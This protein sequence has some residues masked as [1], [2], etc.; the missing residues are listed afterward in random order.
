M[1]FFNFCPL[2]NL[3][4][5]QGM[6]QWI[7]VQIILCFEALKE[8]TGIYSDSERKMAKIFDM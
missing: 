6:N 2:L 8:I 7:S 4:S 5:N 1:H 3:F